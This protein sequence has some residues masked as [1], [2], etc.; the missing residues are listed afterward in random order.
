M[1]GALGALALVFVA[2]CTTASGERPGFLQSM[3]Q[4]V[5]AASMAVGIKAGD[6]SLARSGA[7]MLSEG[8]GAGGGSPQSPGVSAAPVAQADSGGGSGDLQA[9]ADRCN[10]IATSLYSRQAQNVLLQR[11]ACLSY[12]AYTI[13]NIQRYHD[14]YRE[15]QANANSLCSMGMGE[16]NNIST[17]QCTYR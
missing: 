17:A 12:C 1:Q 9:I 10:D 13:T 8:L 3:Q 4:V 6:T 16:C 7:D 2:A 11:A 15:N 14:M 5:G